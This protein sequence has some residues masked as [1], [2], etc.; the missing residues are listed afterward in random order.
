M[1]KNSLAGLKVDPKRQ[2]IASIEGYTYQIWQSIYKWITLKENEVLFLEGAE[3]YDVIGPKGAKTVQVKSTQS[4]FTLRSKKILE[5][6]NNFWENQKRNPDRILEYHFL[7]NAKRGREHNSPFGNKSGF[8]YWE[9]CERPGTDLSPLRKFLINR[10]ELS[11]ELHQ[12]IKDSDDLELINCLIKKIKWYTGSKPSKSIEE[13]VEKKVCYYGD[14][15]GISLSESK[16]VVPHLATH[17]LKVL[18]QKDKRELEYFDF[19]EL[20][21]NVTR[22]SIPRQYLELSKQVSD[23]ANLATKIISTHS[24]GTPRE[25]Q[26]GENFRSLPSFLPDKFVRREKLVS[27]LLN[28]LEDNRILVLRGSTGMGKSILAKL[29]AMENEIEWQWL[30]VRDLKNHEIKELFYH[31]A[32]TL[33]DQVHDLKFVIDDLNFGPQ[34]N[35]YEHAL[36]SLLFALLS[37]NGKVIITTQG[38]IPCSIISNL[39]ISSESFVNVPILSH[40]E[41]RKFA[42]DYGCTEKRKLD[43]WSTIVS[44]KTRGHPQLVHAWIKSL[45]AKNWPDFDI[46]DL[47]KEEDIEIVRREARKRLVEQLPSEGARTLVY[48]LGIIGQPFR[49]DHAIELGEGIPG[50]VSPGEVIDQLLGPWIEKLSAN[51]YRISPLLENAAKAVWGKVRINKVHKEV[52]ETFLACRSLTLLEARVILLSGLVS[53]SGAPI[54]AML[55]S[56]LRAPEKYW[57][58]IADEF[59]WITAVGLEKGKKIFP[60][61]PFVNTYLRLFQFRIAVE[62]DSTNL[63]PKVANLWEKDIEYHKAN[64][65][66]LLDRIM[67]ILKTVIHYQVPFPPKVIISRI[68]EAI[69]LARNFEK[70]FGKPFVLEDSR[71]KYSLPNSLFLFAIV[72]IKTVTDL[73]ELLNALESL[74]EE[75]R[76]ELLSSLKK[77]ID[78]SEILLNNV[79]L[80]EVDSESPQWD[81]YIS[82]LERTIDLAFSW[83]IESLARAAYRTTALINDEQQNKPN[84]A[85]KTLQ[86][87]K[88]KLGYEHPFLGDERAIILYN[89]KN[90]KGALKIWEDILLKWPD[91]SVFSPI[92]HMPFAMDCAANLGMWSKVKEIALLGEKFA[93]LYEKP[94]MVVG[95]HAEYAFALWK[96]R[97]FQEAL[98]AF[99]EVLNLI[100]KL[101]D[102]YKDIHSYKLQKLIGHALAWITQETSDRIQ[103]AEPQPGWFTRQEVD[104]KIKDFPLQPVGFLW[105]F[106]ADLE[107]KVGS[108]CLMFERLKKESK[109]L[110]LPFIKHM[111]EKIRVGRSLKEF[112]FKSLVIELVNWCRYFELSRKHTAADHGAF[113][114]TD[115]NIKISNDEL[116]PTFQQGLPLL[117]LA[118]LIKL[119][120]QNKYLAAPITEWKRYTKRCGYYNDKLKK[121]F[122]LVEDAPNMNITEL[123]SVMQKGDWDIRCIAALNISAREIVKPSVRFYAEFSILHVMKIFPWIEAVDT[124]I[125]QLLSKNWLTVT[126]KQA[127]S[128]IM[129]SIN[130]PLIIK[131]CKDKSQ[132][133]KKA[134]KILLAAKNAVRISIPVGEMKQLK[135]LADS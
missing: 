97:N 28:R 64:E 4:S 7:T 90:F 44:A 88:N 74:S 82:V 48:K 99:A 16:N 101:P 79:F 78:P 60:D 67:F 39:K 14:K 3:D 46:K 133:L 117:L 15:K 132:G 105:Y 103:L 10:K 47:G 106:L 26:I 129:P 51:Y 43:A 34:S 94:I 6:I 69:S 116:R 42:I 92:F 65:L 12:F 91:N 54:M 100:P 24:P 71:I 20:F 76:D 70:V 32:V 23:L 104:E 96:T 63:A 121:L 41:I 68:I 72:R 66:K 18:C 58:K 89:Q 30:N 5:A 119:V 22:V 13:L 61:D 40:D 83:E 118:V 52:A 107:Y 35:I 131:A 93:K 114:K 38:E 113:D 95:F 37:F 124:D 75:N 115:S 21:D 19:V 9:S 108:G 81:Y 130:S 80:N 125:E 102:P 36:E 56:L 31:T 128:L 134:A 122:K 86:K 57:P 98:N 126:S 29:V 84:E 111:V 109:N 11:R 25:L 59:W 55:S 127:F 53:N 120:N 50:L 77:E 112:R 8:D 110:D 33:S 85:L 2:A 27:Q 87:A 1:T 17:V 62:V 135:E 45:E 123:I 49:R 73:N